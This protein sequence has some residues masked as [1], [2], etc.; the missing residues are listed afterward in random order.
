[1]VAENIFPKMLQTKQTHLRSIVKTVSYRVF[2]LICDFV[3]V[4]LFTGKIKV[5][6]AFMII[7]NTYATVGYYFHERIWNKIK[8]G[9]INYN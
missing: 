3:A 7:S 8:W 1:M 9:R 4:Y 6:L 5:A 2:I